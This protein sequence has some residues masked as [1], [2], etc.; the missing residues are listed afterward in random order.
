LESIGERM[1]ARFILAH[2]VARQRAVDAVREADDGLMVTI[3]EQTRNAEQNDKF[4]AICTDLAK[5][6]LVWFG[7]KRTKQQ[8]KVLLVSGHAKATGEEVEI[9]PGLEGE[10]VN[11]RESTALMSVR[12][13]SSLIEYATA[14]CAMQ[15][16]EFSDERQAA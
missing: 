7:R 16:V 8:W 4:H 14:F 11:I 6:G 2:D 3:S 1:K 13:S 12:R 15:G 9:V 5:S 10:M